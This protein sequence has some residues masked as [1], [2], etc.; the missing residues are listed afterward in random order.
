MIVA[1]PADVRYI[2]T[3]QGTTP[4]SHIQANCTFI[5]ADIVA[6]IGSPNPSFRIKDA[7]GFWES[8]SGRFEEEFQFNTDSVRNLL[9]EIDYWSQEDIEKL[10]SLQ[11]EKLLRINQ[12]YTLD[13]FLSGSKQELDEKTISELSKAWGFEFTGK[14]SELLE[15]LKIKN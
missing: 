7:C 3:H 9:K 14:K 12:V 8:M 10:T 2:H 1:T 13:S 11:L 6:F 4:I 15:F 5:T